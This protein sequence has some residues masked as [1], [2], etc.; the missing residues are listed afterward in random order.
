GEGQIMIRIETAYSNKFLTHYDVAIGSRNELIYGYLREEMVSVIPN[1]FLFTFGLLLMLI[2]LVSVLMHSPMP[3]ALSLGSVAVVFTIYTN[4]PLFTNQYIFQNPVT[5]YYL[6]YFALYLL[7]LLAVL[8]F[9]NIVPDLDMKWVFYVFA[10]LDV[11]LTVVHFSGIASYTRTIKIF[12]GSLGAFTVVSVIMIA[13]KFRKITTLRRISIILLLFFMLTNVI[14]FSFVS[15][16]GQ[17]SYLSKIG[18][19]MYIAIAVVDGIQN[20]MKA[21]FKER[22]DELLHEIAYTDN[23]T[24]LG[25]RYALERDAHKMALDS[26]SIVSL[27][28][29]YLKYT[30]DTFGHAGGDVL[31]RCAADC[32]SSVFDKVYR[33]GGDEFIALI[34]KADKAELEAK[35]AALQKK[36]DEYNRKRTHFEAFS[37]NEDFILSIAAGYASYQRDDSSYEQIMNRADEE[38]YHAKK[39][40][41]AN[42][43][44]RKLNVRVQNA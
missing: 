28:L 11:V 37:E 43:S 23:L 27:D 36:A 6:N 3:E 15:T 1:I 19:L 16:L 4:C 30:N 40:M 17:Q 25:N 42:S 26:I 38:M 20:L 29:N 32:I 39:Q 35:T 2:Y 18:L 44:I 7:P 14:F 8:Y 12:V 22:E 34:G 21:F 41:H 9:E 5:Q 13:R 31:L 10:V 33:V 24:K